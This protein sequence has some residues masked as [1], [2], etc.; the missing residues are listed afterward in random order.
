MKTH[1]KLDDFEDGLLKDIEQLEDDLMSVEM[2][3]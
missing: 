3:L 1:E 2:K